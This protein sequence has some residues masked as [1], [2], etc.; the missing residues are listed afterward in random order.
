M[1]NSASIV[2]IRS[3]ADV[4]RNGIIDKPVNR[5]YI[6]HMKENQGSISERVLL[7]TE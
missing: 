5:M 2:F 6:K 4:Y 1:N 3:T 7:L